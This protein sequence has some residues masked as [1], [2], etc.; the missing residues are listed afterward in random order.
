MANQVA[1]VVVGLVAVQVAQAGQLEG[2]IHLV[3]L[4]HSS[5]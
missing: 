1:E 3:V 5:R 4:L 2:H